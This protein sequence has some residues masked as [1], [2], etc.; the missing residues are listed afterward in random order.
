M[1][2]TVVGKPDPNP[3]AVEGG[4]DEFNSGG[5]KGGLNFCY[6]R[7]VGRR[8]SILLLDGYNGPARDT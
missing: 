3:W 4:P 1:A 7:S 2:L 5:L 6:C 8:Y